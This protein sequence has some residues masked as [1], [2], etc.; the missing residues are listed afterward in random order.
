MTCGTDRRPAPTEAA[1]MSCE[2]LATGITR[3]LSHYSAT[4]WRSAAVKLAPMSAGSLDLAISRRLV[5]PVGQS[6][7]LLLAELAHHERH[8][9]TGVTN[10]DQTG[11]RGRHSTD[12]GA[13]R[14]EPMGGD[15]WP[16]RHAVHD[17]GATGSDGTVY[18]ADGGR[19][20]PDHEPPTQALVG[21]VAGET[22]TVPASVDVIDR[23]ATTGARVER[24]RDRSDEDAPVPC[25]TD[26]GNDRQRKVKPIPTPTLWSMTELHRYV[27]VQYDRAPGSGEKLTDV[28]LNYW[29]R[30]VGFTGADAIRRIGE[31]HGAPVGA[32]V[33]YR[34]D[35]GSIGP[36][37]TTRADG[38]VEAS[39][40]RR[41]AHDVRPEIARA[42]VEALRSA[43]L[44]TF[45]PPVLSPERAAAARRRAADRDRQSAHRREV[46]AL[47]RE[48]LALVR[49]VD[50]AARRATALSV[51]DGTV[52]P[53]RA[54]QFAT[55]LRRTA[56]HRRTLADSAGAITACRSVREL[57]AHREALQPIVAAVLNTLEMPT[58]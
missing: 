32:L 2:I 4:P 17:H 3:K 46:T 41:S 20:L 8:R 39:R 52:T 43:L 30:A 24:W 53:E 25:A 9:D 12:T 6:L 38:T 48:V 15:T 47:R 19:L 7:P 40:W 49:L 18:G 33:A 14:C 13:K 31:R 26:I 23:S 22:F 56:D 11:D 37:V 44:L 10:T 21:T 55:A 51:A 34:W 58:L 28:I 35:R 1:P 45:S 42:V 57:E 16:I 27:V 54:D 36:V 50:G 29:P 5:A